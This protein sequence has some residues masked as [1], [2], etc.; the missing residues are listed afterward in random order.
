MNYSLVHWWHGGVKSQISSPW[1]VLFNGSLNREESVFSASE[2]SYGRKVNSPDWKLPNGVG[3]F[4]QD[5]ITTGKTHPSVLLP[6]NLYDWS[7]HIGWERAL[8][9]CFNQMYCFG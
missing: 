6:Y 1:R 4:L 7:I 3:P 2:A 9:F 8:L 5:Y